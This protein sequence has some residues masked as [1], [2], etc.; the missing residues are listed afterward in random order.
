ME[1]SAAVGRSEDGD[2]RPASRRPG[3]L[4]YSQVMIPPTPFVTTINLWSDILK[5]LTVIFTG[6]SNGARPGRNIRQDL[7]LGD[8]QIGTYQV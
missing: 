2:A 8:R 1:T 7:A 5:Q 3:S 6:S 4:R